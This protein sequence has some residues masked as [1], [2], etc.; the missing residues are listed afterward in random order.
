MQVKLSEE[1]LRIL[2]SFPKNHLGGSFILSPCVCIVVGLE[3]VPAILLKRDSPQRVFSSWAMQ[4]SSF[5]KFGKFS[6]RCFHHRFSN[7]VAGLQSIISPIL[8]KNNHFVKR[9][10]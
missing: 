9:P 4:D 7:K 2:I 8:S 10:R 3:S 6:E 1:V 5:E